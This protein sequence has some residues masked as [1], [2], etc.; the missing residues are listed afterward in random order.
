MGF[1]DTIKNLL[2]QYAEGKRLEAF[3][4][5]YRERETLAAEQVKQA[6]LQTRGLEQGVERGDLSIQQL[7][8]QM[9]QEQRLRGILQEAVSGGQL[10]ALFEASPPAQAYV[11]GA[12]GRARAERAGQRAEQREE[13]EALAAPT[14]EEL[15]EK[16]ELERRAAE[17][18]IGY[19]Q[20][21]GRAATT[22]A[23]L[24][25]ARGAGGR[26]GIKPDAVDAETTIAPAQAAAIEAFG[27]PTTIEERMQVARAT[28]QILL[29]NGWSPD[30][31][32][33]AGLDI[34]FIDEAGRAASAEGAAAAPAEDPLGLF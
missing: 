17:A 18:D 8:D 31:L 4:P 3:G 10:P 2:A 27:E 7:R 5:G 13:V 19:R 25:G 29:A 12:P 20:A 1:G 9:E 28:A 30:A 23:G 15:L 11:E 32:R 16:R 26:G 24:A 14:V 6:P 33:R 22:R 34:D 21:M